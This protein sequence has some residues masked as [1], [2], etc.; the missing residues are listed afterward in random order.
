MRRTGEIRKRLRVKSREAEE[1]IAELVESC[2]KELEIAGVYGD[3]EDP[4]YFQ[5][6]VLYCKS[7]FGYDEG[8]ERFLQA[9][10]SLRDSMALSGD[11]KKEGAT[12]WKQQY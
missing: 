5:A 8:T 7:H 6:L 4:V 3:E 1:E 11:Y 12:K 9:F 2:K 10:K